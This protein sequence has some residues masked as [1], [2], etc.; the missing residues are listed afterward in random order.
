MCINDC[1]GCS[2]FCLENE[3]TE[4]PRETPD[5]Q[6]SGHG[7]VQSALDYGETVN[8]HCEVPRLSHSSEQRQHVECLGLLFSRC[9]T[10]VLQVSTDTACDF[11]CKGSL[12]QSNE[13]KAV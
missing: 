11:C 5:A 8:I 3:L 9:V 7:S 6:Q 10:A 13:T 4:E 12:D 1:C 2:C